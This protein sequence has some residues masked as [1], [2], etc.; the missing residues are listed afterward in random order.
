[1]WAS[2]PLGDIPVGKN[3]CPTGFPN[4]P[5]HGDFL[6]R[7]RVELQCHFWF[8]LLFLFQLRDSAPGYLVAWVLCRSQPLTHVLCSVNAKDCDFLQRASCGF[9]GQAT[10]GHLL[11]VQGR[12]V[13]LLQNE[14]QV[15][16]RKALA[17]YL[18]GICERAA[19]D[20]C[21]FSSLY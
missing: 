7:E 1:M 16:L 17:A 14:A 19:K 4:T 3:K 12:A 2:L 13:G 6:P 5:F 8:P 15:A 20:A 10:K 11:C 21:E 18:S 9:Q